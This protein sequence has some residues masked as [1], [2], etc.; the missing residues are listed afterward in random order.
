MEEIDAHVAADAQVTD[1]FAFGDG[2]SGPQ[3]PP[4]RRSR[5]RPITTVYESLSRFLIWPGMLAALAVFRLPAE[6]PGVSSVP[7]CYVMVFLTGVGGREEAAA[8]LTG[9]PRLARRQALIEL[10]PH[11]GEQVSAREGWHKP[12]AIPVVGQDR[13]YAPQAVADCILYPRL[14]GPEVFAA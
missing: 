11:G 7:A 6:K 12:A 13:G 10:E 9:T 4:A 3:R 2:L 14:L 1:E 8:A 5:P